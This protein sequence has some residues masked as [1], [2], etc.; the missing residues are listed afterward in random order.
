MPWRLGRDKELKLTQAAGRGQQG[1]MW[2]AVSG[3]SGAPTG[4]RRGSD[5]R[6]SSV[7]VAPCPHKEKLLGPAKTHMGRTTKLRPLKDES[8]THGAERSGSQG[9]RVAGPGTKGAWIGRRGWEPPRARSAHH[10]F[11]QL[12][13]PVYIYNEN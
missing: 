9:G 7:P 5:Q 3:H 2:T 1:C 10:P 13:C 4:G 11:P 8:I 12:S 6:F